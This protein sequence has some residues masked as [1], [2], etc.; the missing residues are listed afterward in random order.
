M[1]PLEIT[2]LLVNIPV[3][4]WCLSASGRPS[5]ARV[6]VSVALLIMAVQIAVEGRRWQFYPA[7]VVTV[8]LFLALPWTQ[9][10]RPGLW[11]SLAGLTGLIISAAFCTVLP[12]FQFPAPTGPFP[13]GTVTRHLIDGSRT[14][15][16]GPVPGAHRELMIQIWYPAEYRG[17]RRAYRSR[18]ELSLFKEHLSLIMTNASA[19]IPLERTPGRLPVLIFS[20]SWAGRRDQNTIQVE[21]FASQGYLVVGIDHPYGTKLTVFPDGRALESTLGEW[22]DFSS[23]AAMQTSKVIAESQLQVRTADVRFV[24]DTLEQLDQCDPEGLFTGRVDTSRAGVFGHS[25]G[26]AVAAEACHLDRRFQAGVNLDGCLFGKS[27]KEGIEQP[28]LTMS[29]DSPLPAT[30][31]AAHPSGPRRRR[32]LFLDQ[33]VQDIRRSVRRHGGYWLSIRGA[34]HLNYCDSPFFT[35]VRRFSGAGSIDRR[36]AMRIVNDF[37]LGFFNQYVL[38]REGALHD[39]PPQRYPEVRIELWQPPETRHS[40]PSKA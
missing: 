7:Y 24:L 8:W 14:E 31:L 3:L 33:D 19:A 15:S 16:L 20:P 25:F 28:F 38:G 12:A 6:M 18:A 37:T 26:G 35:P 10:A 32:L 34:S 4:S 9:M 13:V 11:T 21:E 2:L 27:A 22:M 29:D 17:P 5:W 39:V 40:V 36:R 30:S 23:D 1:R